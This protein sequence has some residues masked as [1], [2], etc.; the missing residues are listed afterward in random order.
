[1]GSFGQRPRPRRAIETMNRASSH[2]SFRGALRSGAQGAQRRLD[3]G[4]RGRL[5]N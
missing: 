1:M 3:F 4:S 2:P 5:L